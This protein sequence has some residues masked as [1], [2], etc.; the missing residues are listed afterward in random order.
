MPYSYRA[1]RSNSSNRHRSFS[2]RRNN[3]V[4]TEYID[5]SRFIK[6]AKATEEE[7]YQPK[8]TFSDFD[9]CDLIKTPIVQLKIMKMN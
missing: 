3:R 8:H 2:P 4:K 7:V 5:P 1:K 6:V 9:I